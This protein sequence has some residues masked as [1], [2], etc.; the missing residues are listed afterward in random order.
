MHLYSATVGPENSDQVQGEPE[1]WEETVGL[2]VR[3]GDGSP[4]LTLKE[5]PLKM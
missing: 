1:M 3:T 5:L 2:W 4:K